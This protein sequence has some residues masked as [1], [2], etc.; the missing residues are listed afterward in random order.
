[1]NH[2]EARIPRVAENLDHNRKVRQVNTIATA[3]CDPGVWVDVLQATD[4][5]NPAVITR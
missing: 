4:G 2:S 5:P 1:M 3:C